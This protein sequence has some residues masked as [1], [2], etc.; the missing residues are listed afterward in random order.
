LKS[1]RI[2]KLSP[3]Q[4][5]L[6]KP[7]FYEMLL[8]FYSSLHSI[9]LFTHAQSTS[10]TSRNIFQ[11]PFANRHLSNL[12]SATAVNVHLLPYNANRINLGSAVKTWKNLYLSGNVYKGAIRFI[13]SDT[14]ENTLVGL[15]AG[16][17]VS[18]LTNS[19]AITGNRRNLSDA[20]LEQ[21]KPNPSNGAINIRYHLPSTNNN[22][23]ILITDAKG[24]FIKRLP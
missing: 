23:R 13:G 17:V 6:T 12:R 5:L 18:K 19:K 11:V 3:L 7:I 2:P 16:R 20:Y 1:E 4:Y 21:S 14:L 10:N 24:S 9:G 15:S 8:S 22:A